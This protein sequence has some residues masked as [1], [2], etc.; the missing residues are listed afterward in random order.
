MFVEN[1]L[2][3]EFSVS[4]NNSQHFWGSIKLL[5]ISEVTFSSSGYAPCGPF[6]KFTIVR[7]NRKRFYFRDLEI[8]IV[9]I[10]IICI[11]FF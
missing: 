8:F 11:I 4:N 3:S 2:L 9:F 6:Y 1:S 5:S 10:N 7:V